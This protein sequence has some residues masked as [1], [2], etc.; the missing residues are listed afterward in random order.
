VSG[1]QRHAKSTTQ[2]KVGF[3]ATLSNLLHGQGTST[4]SFATPALTTAS[5]TPT[6]PP[7]GTA[8]GLTAAWGGGAAGQA[9]ARTQGA[10]LGGSKH[11]SEDA[12]TRSVSGVSSVAWSHGVSRRSAPSSRRAQSL[13][14]AL[15]LA[16][17]AF[18]ITAAPASAAPPS[19][20]MG[21][22]SNVFYTT[23]HVTGF[24]TS[25][26]SGAFG[27]TTWG[28]QYSTD[29]VNWSVGYAT[30]FGTAL[31]GAFTDK[32]VEA[33]IPK[34][35]FPE[36]QG[37]TKYFVRLF[38][39]NGGFP[40]ADTEVFSPEPNPSFTTL[41]VDPPTI[42]GTV[43]AS[44]VFSTSA[45]AIG[46]VKRPANPADPKPGADAAFDV[47]CHFDYITDAQYQDN[48]TNIGPDAGFQGSTPVDCAQNPIQ[49][50]DA[51]T[52]KE[53]TAALA[54]LTPST[55][56]RLRLVAENAAPGVVTKVAAATFTTA[57][58][59]AAPTVIA[60]DNA[61]EVK[62]NSAKFTGKVLR[63]AGDDPALNVNCRFEYITDV[64]FLANEGASE[65]GFT[66]AQP[67]DC[68]QNTIK[69]ASETTVSAKAGLVANTTYHLRLVAENEG[70]TDTK[71]AAATFT[72]PEAELPVVTID[73]V[74]GGTF[75]TAHVSGTIERDDPNPAFEIVSGQFEISTDN[76]NWS[77]G[78]YF[79]GIESL[80]N[81]QFDFSGL[82]PSTTYFFRIAGT[83]SG[84]PFPDAVANGEVAYSPE[85]NPSITTEP[86]SAP[87]TAE[88]LAVTNVTATTAHFS[89]T[90]DP[91][92][93]AG[94]LS[95][96]AKKAYETKW[97]FECTPE[98]KD[99]NG[100]EIGGTIQGEEGS[101]PVFG[102]AKRL[103]PGTEYEVRLIV[104][105]E[106]GGETKT[107]TFNTSKIPPSVKQSLG[108]SDGEGGYTLQGV[109]NPNKET[110]T[111]CEFKW[112]PNAPAYA[113]SAP[114]SPLPS[115]GVKPTTV[116]AHLTSL[117]PDVDYHALLVVTYG[118]G[119]KA[120][121]G[122]DQIFKATFAAK[123]P[124]PNGQQRA[125]NSS[126]ALPECRAYEMVSPPG[127]EGFDALS[128]VVGSNAGFDG[129]ERFA[130]V[131]G[132]GNIAKS[133][134]G[135]PYNYYVAERSS[136]GW[137]TI[138][139]LNGSSGSL[140]DA[141]IYAEGDP[142]GTFPTAY[143]PD[144]RSS[145]WSLTKNGCNRCQYLRSPDGTFALIGSAYSA[146]NSAFIAPNATSADLSHLVTWSSNRG[147][148]IYEF[149]GTGMGQPRRADLDNSGAPI[150]TCTIAGL[151]A[152]VASNRFV[153]SDGGTI[154]NYVA[155]G[156]GGTNPPADELWARVNGATAVDVA[157]SH[158][159]RVAPACNA[160]SNPKFEAATPDGSR[161][162]FTTSQQLVDADT[163]QTNDV[164]ACDIPSGN[165]APTPE[166]SNPC[167]AFHQVSGAQT[168]AD[169]ESFHASSENGT[170]VLFTAKGVL[171]DNEDALEEKAVAGDHNLYV[172]RT[173]AAHPDGQ[174][175]FVGRLDSNGISAQTTPDGRYLVFTT[176][177]QLLDTD[178]DS[179]RDVYRFDADTGDL[180]RVSTNVFGVAGNG[181][182][183]DAR[184]GAPTE[185]DPS[186]TLSN[187]GTKIVFTTAEALSPADGN[188]EP[189]V[190]LWTPSRV[191]LISTGS[192][193]SAPRDRNSGDIVNPG[194][195]ITGSGA[196][197]Y[198]N[199]AQPL[200]PADG[201][202]ATDFYDARIGG[203]FSFAQAVPCSGEKCQPDA[204]PPPPKKAPLSAQPGPGNPP[205]PK[206]CPKGK[207]RKQK[208]K[209]VKKHKKHS[210]KK[211][212]HKQ[213]GG[214]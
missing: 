11:K 76:V 181:E 122:E 161:V 115:P 39:N 193:G 63:P 167:A 209:C 179:A 20:K 55:T 210:G 105:S 97:H 141:P 137:K 96:L 89:G 92:A 183:L 111:A 178:T 54:G 93:P 148:G 40:G 205:P 51:D 36:L 140:Y 158:C 180:T 143:S 188:A 136:T 77:A 49:E 21:T 200:T 85:P 23:A 88:N 46:K 212:S 146:T 91:H 133:G 29:Q 50:A 150:S 34:P 130:F 58:K 43:E 14:T 82:Q 42:P 194:V 19:I 166:K 197:I 28:I 106:G 129:G 118:A 124:C 16:I 61:F 12:A 142:G 149:V 114:C 5:A 168:G 199:S 41:P 67:V 203:G 109:V 170:T 71:V 66:G 176:T 190:Y 175:A 116:E 74:E 171:A 65:P 10:A 1:S 87:P 159:D 185:H 187:D 164:Y 60:T 127:K 84:L 191:S 102:D 154:V 125:E 80:L 53:V 103:E 94:P 32:P 132:A 152:A 86:P 38:A 99:A 144:L 110:I 134:Q 81:R 7:K 26:G 145:K 189:D 155:G 108:A 198:F 156:C 121:S 135:L 192:S 31:V 25:D 214:K 147:P 173:D 160:P 131:S 15:A 139:N 120:D 3:F 90:V 64:Q 98:C 9:A 56:Y 101:Q 13:L 95:P 59:V 207:V 48:I 44:P 208:G 18:A 186:A 30:D 157:A 163:D 113:F 78:Q 196:D 2:P 206:P 174:T 37:G 52:E 204:T 138:P 162:F 202:G 201:D 151:G 8:S 69:N 165:P 119:L 4:P 35:G 100:N 169:L 62:S 184:T 33:D 45:K 57:A 72:T 70:G 172:W 75:T 73:P 123:E 6:H 17:T 177:S 112:G 68:E 213:G 24:V 83:Y 104:S 195:G 79:N 153:S 117:N 107:E 182:G 211:A 22:I 27:S 126:L 47:N 128:G